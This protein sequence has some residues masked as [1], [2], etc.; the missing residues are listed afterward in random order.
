LKKG[1]SLAFSAA[2]MA[3]LLAFAVVPTALGSYSQ[4]SAGTVGRGQTSSGTASETLTENAQPPNTAIACF[5]NGPQAYGA[6]GGYISQH[7]TDSSGTGAIGVGE[8]VSI[9]GPVSIV[10]PGSLG[11]SVILQSV[12]GGTNNVLTIKLTGHDDFNVEAITVSFKVAA[13]A[14]SPNGAIKGYFDALPPPGGG[15]TDNNLCVV[16]ALSSTVT[17]SGKL[18]FPMA[19]G[20]GGATILMDA[21]SCPFEITNVASGGP[22]EADQPNAGK[23]NF[24]SNAETIPIATDN[25]DGIGGGVQPLTFVGVTVNAH[26]A[27]EVVNQTVNN[28]ALAITE[29]LLKTGTVGTVGPVLHNDAGETIAATQVLPGQNNQTGGTDELDDGT[30]AGDASNLNGLTVTFTINTAGVVFSA[31]PPVTYESDAAGPGTCT[32]S[33]DRKS[34]TVGPLT[35]AAAVGGAVEIAPLLDV[36]ASVPIGTAVTVTKTT[37]PT[38]AV[39]GNPAT[40]ANVGRVIVGSATPTNIIIGFNGQKLAVISLRESGPG[41]FQSGISS[42][43]TFAKCIETGEIFTRAPW[44][45]VTTGDLKLLNP[46]TAGPTSQIQGTLYNYN[47]LGARCVYWTVFSGSTVASTIE[48]R[49]GDA[50]GPATTGPEVNVPTGLP[51]GSEQDAILVGTNANVVGSGGCSSVGGC[52][53]NPAFTG[54]VSAANRV[55]NGAIIVA[56]VSQP[57][58]NQGAIDV[59]EGNI[60]LTETGALN[61]QFRLGE[62]ITLTIV[63]PSSALH[64]EVFINT[65]ST[66]DSPIILT[67]AAASGLLTTAP[68]VVCPTLLPLF[69]LCTITFVVSQQ[70]FGPAAGVITITNVHKNILVDAHNGPVFEQITGGGGGSTPF[71]AVVS[72]LIIGPP[73]VATSI[74]NGSALGVTKT[75]PFTFATKVTPHGTYVTWQAHMSPALAGEKVSVWMATKPI[76]GT[77][78]SSFAPFSSRVVDASGNA[79]FYFKSTSARWVSIKFS[80]A[81]NSAHSAT[82]SLSRVAKYT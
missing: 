37:S 16:P 48:L 40:I 30:F 2:L 7:F 47:A 23:L 44:A 11:A 31:A 15:W 32:L 57:T 25:A 9:V 46:A 77:T 29:P 55:F 6:S 36:D 63:A 58:A 24:V 43:N 4:T 18:A 21:G 27:S 82:T 80:F 1:A 42:N 39:S 73:A 49:G 50:S 78:W 72:P 61:G 26:A 64:N 66:A 59:L 20:A 33:L 28:C 14:A 10:A 74:T 56:A 38:F 65:T 60:T 69:N 22:G 45:V 70:S 62:V 51:A 35:D 19:A 52:A 12:G 53:G 71:Q 8:T 75:G 3:S 34:C 5:G 67:N 76:G 41:F 79:Y 17:A 13:G 68:V 54:A 81:G